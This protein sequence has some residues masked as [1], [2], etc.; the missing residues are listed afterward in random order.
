ML[1]GARRVL[2]LGFDM[3]VVGD[4]RHFFGDH[5]KPLIQASPYDLFIKAFTVIADDA[6]RLGVEI[7][8]CTPGSALTQFPILPLDDVR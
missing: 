2:L 5:P 6:K 3:R 4:Q 7:I 8:N 1:W